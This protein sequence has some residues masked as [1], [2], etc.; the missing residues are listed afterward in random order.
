M[1]IRGLIQS[2]I[3]TEIT[4]EAEDAQ[5]ARA[6]VEEQVPEGYDLIQVHKASAR[7]GRVIAT[8]KI[9]AAAVDELDATG[10]DYQSARAALLAKMPADH[11]LLSVLSL[12]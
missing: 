3:V 1:R 2:T 4:A 12:D 10:S 11:R 7:G 8:G 6:M 5:A 9:R